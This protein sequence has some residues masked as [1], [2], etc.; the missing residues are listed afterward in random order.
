MKP[1]PNGIE[2][3]YPPVAY[4]DGRRTIYGCDELIA[5]AMRR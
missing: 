2:Y 3:V 4:P 5:T 1:V